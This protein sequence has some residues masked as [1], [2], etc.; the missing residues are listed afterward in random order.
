[1][2]TRLVE[3]FYWNSG[4]GGLCGSFFHLERGLW[5]QQP[6][7]PVIHLHNGCLFIHY[8]N[9]MGGKLGNKGRWGEKIALACFNILFISKHC[10]LR[11]AE[12]QSTPLP[13][14]SVFSPLSYK[15]SQAEEKKFVFLLTFSASFLER[16]E[17]HNLKGR[18][19]SKLRFPS[20]ESG[21]SASLLIGYQAQM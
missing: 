17:Q 14:T 18:K 1:M 5:L 21:L 6:H 7:S 11:K 20:F 15:L 2:E 4:I 9:G 19:K 16:S 13:E 3:H 10:G 8:A 12:P